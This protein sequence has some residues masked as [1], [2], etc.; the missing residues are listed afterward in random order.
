MPSLIPTDGALPSK[1]FSS[2]AHA[3]A[4]LNQATTVIKMLR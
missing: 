4:T 1:N 3:N 2:R